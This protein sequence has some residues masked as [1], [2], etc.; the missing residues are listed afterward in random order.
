[1][2]LQL[3]PTELMCWPLSVGRQCQCTCTVVPRM[4]QALLDGLQIQQQAA[5]W[6]A[7]GDYRGYS[8]CQSGLWIHLLALL[9]NSDCMPM[10]VASE[11]DANGQDVRCSFLKVIKDLILSCPDSRGASR[12]FMPAFS[13]HN[14]GQVLYMHVLE[15]MGLGVSWS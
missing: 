2:R 6:A 7:R 15:P 11:G 13:L 9:Y 4:P 5:P 8:V 3:Q 12:L 10:A 1:M 14:A